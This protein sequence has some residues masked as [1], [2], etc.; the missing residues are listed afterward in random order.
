MDAAARTVTTVRSERTGPLLDLLPAA[1]RPVLGAARR[2]EV[3]W[4][5]A[6]RLE[7]SGPGALAEAS[8][9]WADFTAGP[10]VE[11]EVGVPGS[12]PVVF[13]GVALDPARGRRSSSSP[14]SWWAGAT[15][16]AG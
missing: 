2:G 12:G 14:R 6:A 15:G 8:A 10:D 5:E 1:R 11:D 9:W 7:V 3:A 13:A 16:S 4:G